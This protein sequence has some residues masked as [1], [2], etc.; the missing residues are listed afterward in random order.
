MIKIAVGEIQK[1]YE[2]WRDLVREGFPLEDTLRLVTSNPAKRAGI[3]PSKGALEEGKDAD[4]LILNDDL[5][6]ETVMAKG[7]LMIHR[8][9]VLIKGTF[10]E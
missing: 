1:L 2:E 5:K 3:F 9:E 6:L 4:L 7:R 10:E 8:G